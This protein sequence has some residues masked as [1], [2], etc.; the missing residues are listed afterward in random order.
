MSV[1]P[2][3]LNGDRTARPDEDTELWWSV[4][5]MAAL[6]QEKGS[7]DPVILK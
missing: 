7:L 2:N 5:A 4:G 1:L 6:L 3:P